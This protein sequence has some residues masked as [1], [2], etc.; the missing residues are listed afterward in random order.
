[1]LNTCI[2]ELEE[3]IGNSLLLQEKYKP[4]IQESSHPYQ[5]V[6][7]VKL[8]G[9][10]KF[11]DAAMLSV[12]FNDQCQTETGHD[13]LTFYDH[14]GRTL[15][16]RTGHLPTDWNTKLKVTGE[17]LNWSFTTNSPGGLWGFK[18]IVTPIPPSDDGEADTWSDDAVLKT[19]CLELV[20]RLLS[21]C[22]RILSSH[23]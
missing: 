16:V 17:E 12:E 5:G 13:V 9:T 11:P 3:K 6:P 19:P 18:F 15:A 4:C 2:H 1:M 21:K 8:S 23:S 20:K 7:G 22:F 14:S 10:V